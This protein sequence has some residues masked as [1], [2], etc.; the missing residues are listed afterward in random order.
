M[1]KASNQT[2]TGHT[3]GTTEWT[4]TATTKHNHQNT[5][6]VPQEPLRLLHTTTTMTTYESDIEKARPSCASAHRDALTP[7][8]PSTPPHQCPQQPQS[9]RAGINLQPTEEPAEESTPAT[10]LR[11]PRCHATLLAQG[12]PSPPPWVLFMDKKSTATTI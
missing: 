1:H 10:P 11:R 2:T 7:T 3:P 12:S 8:A 6:D 5:A 9:F 4:A